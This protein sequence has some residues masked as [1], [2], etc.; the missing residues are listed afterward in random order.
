MTR[1]A[2]AAK[3]QPTPQKP[4]LRLL[5]CICWQLMRILNLPVRGVARVET[6]HTCD[7]PNLIW[8]ALFTRRAYSER[9]QPAGEVSVI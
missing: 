4:R 7:P 3:P 6:G 1:C 9:A 2:V 8:R 5:G